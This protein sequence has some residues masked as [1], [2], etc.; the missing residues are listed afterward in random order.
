MKIL[1][2]GHRGETVRRN[3]TS[4]WSDSTSQRMT[5]VSLSTFSLEGV[6]LRKM[7]NSICLLGE[8]RTRLGELQVGKLVWGLWI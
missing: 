3:L 6:E 4:V 2:Q 1:I 8:I 7:R 5:L